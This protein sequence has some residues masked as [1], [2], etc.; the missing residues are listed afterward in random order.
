[1]ALPGQEAMVL[2]RTTSRR[3]SP[4]GLLELGGHLFPGLFHGGDAVVEGHEVSPVTVQGKAGGEVGLD[5]PEA[6]AL[7]T[8][9]LDEPLDGITGHAEVMFEGHLCG[10]LDLRGGAAT[11]RA[12]SGRCHC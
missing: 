10:V 2:R 11:H 6:V 8:G 5:G 1:M 4:G 12:E 9:D 7:D 3:P